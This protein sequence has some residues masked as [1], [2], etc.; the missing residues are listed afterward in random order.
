M[1]RTTAPLT[2]TACRS[3]KPTDRAYKLFDGDGLY[4]LVQPNGRKGW[5]FRYV[6]PDGREGLTS[7]GNY[8]VITLADARRKRLEAKRQLANGI[9]PIESKRDAK[10]TAAINGRTFEEVALDWHKEMS[11]KWA[12]GHSKTVLS[13]LK[14]HVFPLIGARPIVELDTHDLMTPLEAIKKRGTIDVALRVQNYLQSI[15]REAKR[16]RLITQNPAH[17]LEGS[18][19]APRVKH[20]PALPLARLPELLELIDTYRGRALTR[21]TVMLSLHVFVRSSELR[22]ARW[23]EFDLKRGIWEIPDT[24]PAL[25]GVPFSTRGTKM[26]G[27][28]H[29]VPLSPHAVTLL[30]QIHKITGKFDLVFAGDAKPW[31]P[32]SENTVNAALRTMGYDTRADICGHGFR[33]MA[34]SALIESGLWS[35]TAIE[36]QMSHKERNNVRA[37]YIHKAE[38]L[39][40]RR[41][42]MT[43]WSRFLEANREDHVTPHEF[44]KQSGENVTRIRSARWTE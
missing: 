39:E 10:T 8:P 20:R 22:F 15:M 37:A 29:L 3:A 18:I 38:F 33:A 4:L 21:L 35:E 43:W 36:R 7:F 32:M 24:R 2:D 13:R 44:A 42:I 23:N 19:K 27:D 17:D 9:D 30:E 41:M 28:I 6:K 31:K 16:L 14:T 25:D 40:E 1:S 26:A 34:C 5:R 12:P 11:A